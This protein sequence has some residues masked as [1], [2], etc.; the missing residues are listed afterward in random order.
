MRYSR[1]IRQPTRRQCHRPAT[2]QCRRYFSLPDDRSRRSRTSAYARC[3]RRL[4]RI[5]F[6]EQRYYLFTLF[7][8]FTWRVEHLFFSFMHNVS[9]I[10]RHAIGCGRRRSF[11]EVFSSSAERQILAKYP[12]QVEARTGA[13][14]E[15]AS[16]IYTLLPGFYAVHGRQPGTPAPEA[17]YLFNDGAIAVFQ[18]APDQAE[19]GAAAEKPG[20]VYALQGGGSPAVP[21]GL[22]LI[23]FS[24]E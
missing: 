17:A 24:G 1:R 2:F 3:R 4:L 5:E 11:Q 7:L 20:P 6:G 23:R 22:I 13:G 15:P 9:E 21:T 19:V 18:G 12:Q 16:A 8:R 10:D 14:T